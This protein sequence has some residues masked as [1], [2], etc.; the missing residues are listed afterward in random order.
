LAAHAA[1]AG[2]SIRAD[3]VKLRCR[4]SETDEY[5][6][7]CGQCGALVSLRNAV[8]SMMPAFGM[9]FALQQILAGSAIADAQRNAG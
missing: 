3:A 6:N 2:A 8:E 7:F 4:H 1:Q 9:A 5:S